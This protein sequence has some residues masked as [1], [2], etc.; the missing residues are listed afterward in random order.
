MSK[1]AFKSNLYRYTRALLNDG[2][3]HIKD[4]A[5]DCCRDCTDLPGC[6]VWVFCE[7]GLSLPGGSRV[8]RL[9][10]W[11]IHNYVVVIN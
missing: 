4:S 9:V 2:A 3:K 5:E 1:F 6:N 7:V 8:T 11:T 10:T